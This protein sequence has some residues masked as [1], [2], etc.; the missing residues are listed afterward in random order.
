M[1]VQGSRLPTQRAGTPGGD[2]PTVTTRQR[3][4]E[5]KAGGGD[6]V[7]AATGHPESRPGS[8]GISQRRSYLLRLRCLSSLWKPQLTQ[9]GD[10]ERRDQFPPKD[11]MVGV[12]T[13]GMTLTDS[14]VFISHTLFHVHPAEQK[15]FPSWT[16][17]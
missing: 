9:P 3:L 11:V 13:P 7:P 10:R 1:Q 5:E 12:L 2:S 16:H 17:Q 14:F 6:K 8:S 15:P 4:A